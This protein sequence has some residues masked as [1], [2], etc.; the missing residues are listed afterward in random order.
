MSNATHRRESEEV[1]AVA[2]VPGLGV[3]SLRATASTS[4][5]THDADI[6][7]VQAW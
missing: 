6:A 2:V 4:V 3:H 5:L 7:K 1:G